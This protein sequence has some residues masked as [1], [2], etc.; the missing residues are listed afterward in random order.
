MSFRIKICKQLIFKKN[1]FKYSG[2][3]FTGGR[4]TGSDGLNGAPCNP[5]IDLN[6]IHH[7]STSCLI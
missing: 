7:T 4:A 2:S 3:S 6:T 5:V 1:T